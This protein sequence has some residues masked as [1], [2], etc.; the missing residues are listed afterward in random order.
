MNR[1]V[2]KVAIVSTKGGV[3]KSTV[4]ANLCMALFRSGFPVLGVDL[5]PQNALHLHFGG[6]NDRLDGIS[7]ATL[8]AREWRDAAYQ[9]DTGLAVLP[10]GLINESDRHE[11]EKRLTQDA[12]WL[13]RNLN[14]LPIAPETIVIIDTPP[15]PSTYLQQALTTADLVIVVTLADAAS[16]ATLPQ[17]EKLICNFCTS[18]D[19]FLGHS[20]LVNQYDPNKAL[21]QD[22]LQALREQLPDSTVEP[23]K[24][25]QSVGE[26]LAYG[27]TLI[28]Y[29][30]DSIVNQDYFSWAKWILDHLEVTL[31][32]T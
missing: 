18:R 19:D 22:V 27:K 12:H 32:D 25:N 7:R 30:P 21:S 4:S 16:Y 9:V 1:T 13:E 3:G 6:R 10:Y 15:G 14:Q 2:K 23:V 29:R 28:E 24:F 8:E 5:D 31:P 11:F 26:A 20:Y 17:M